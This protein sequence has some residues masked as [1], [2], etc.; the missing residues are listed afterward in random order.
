MGAPHGRCIKVRDSGGMSACAVLIA[1]MNARGAPKHSQY[2]C[3]GHLALYIY[4]YI[5]RDIVCVDRYVYVCEM[6]YTHETQMHQALDCQYP[7]RGDY[8]SA[9]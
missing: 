1:H 8:G 4:I 2:M 7:W 3:G 5:E 9:S 6:E